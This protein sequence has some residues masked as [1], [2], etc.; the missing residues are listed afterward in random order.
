[1]HAYAAKFIALFRELLPSTHLQ[2]EREEIYFDEWCIQWLRFLLSR[3]LA[4]GNVVRLWDTYIALDA[5]KTEASI[6][7]LLEFHMYACI[8]I[9]ECCQGDLAQLE[10]GEIK[11]FLQH[12]PVMDMD[13]IIT[14]ASY[15]QMEVQAK[16]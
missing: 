10:H 5:G 11:K 2:L 12:L 14:K 9:L 13:K 7:A 6:S 16:R 8:A 15:I 1:M 3:E 4:L